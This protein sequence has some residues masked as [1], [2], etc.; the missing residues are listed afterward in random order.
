MFSLLGLLPGDSFD[1]VFPGTGI[2]TKAWNEL[3]CSGQV[4]ATEE[5]AVGS[6]ESVDRSPSTLEPRVGTHL[7]LPGGVNEPTASVIV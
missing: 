5:M 7:E 2:V 1:D 3:N 6:R 4:K